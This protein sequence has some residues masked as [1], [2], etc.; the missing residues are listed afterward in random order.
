MISILLVEVE[1][2]AHC[3]SDHS[4][5]WDPVLCKNKKNQLIQA[6]TAVASPIKVDCTLKL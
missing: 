5:G 1:R 4:L 2:P 6:P 3:G